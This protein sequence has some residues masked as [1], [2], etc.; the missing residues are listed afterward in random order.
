MC[1]PH[2]SCTVLVR[3]RPAFVP[4]VWAGPSLPHTR[5]LTVQISTDAV[6]LPPEDVRAPL[7]LELFLFGRFQTGCIHWWAAK[8]RLRNEVL[9]LGAENESPARHCH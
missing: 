8:L 4:L 2:R 3:T 7:F 5:N 9:N 6:R 1:G